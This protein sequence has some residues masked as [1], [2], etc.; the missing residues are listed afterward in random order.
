M[1]VDVGIG[2]DVHH[3]DDQ[4]DDDLSPPREPVRVQHGKKILR[5]EITGVI[6]EPRPGAERIF[7]RRQRTNPPGKFNVGRPYGGRHMRPGHGRP[8]KR[9]QRAARS[10]DHEY[11]VREDDQTGEQ[12]IRICHDLIVSFAAKQVMR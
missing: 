11:Q 2:A 6:V 8:A 5:D 12:R 10:K 9:Q 1:E 3:K 4:P 7:Q